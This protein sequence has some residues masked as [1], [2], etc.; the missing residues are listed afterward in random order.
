[1]G[2]LPEDEL[3]LVEQNWKYL[4]NVIREL[5]LISQHL[6]DKNQVLPWLVGGSTGCLLQGV[7]L[8]REPN[9]LDIYTDQAYVHRLHE[10]LEQWVT[11]PET[12]SATN[13]YTSYRSRYRIGGV[14]I[15]LV[16][17]L[18][19]QTNRDGTYRVQIHNLLKPGARQIHIRS[20]TISVMPLEHELIFNLLRDRSDRFKPIARTIQARGIDRPLWERLRA[21]NTLSDCI[22]ERAESLIEAASEEERDE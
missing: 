17:D 19:V 8:K 11:Q 16:A 2:H 22:W 5:G 21:C 12:F 7:A 13:R 10:R 14:E 15:E 6:N 18:S 9:D 4:D 20:E 1:M 3:G